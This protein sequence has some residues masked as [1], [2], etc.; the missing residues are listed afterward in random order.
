MEFAGR[1]AHSNTCSLGKCWKLKTGE[2]TDTMIRKMKNSVDPYARSYQETD[3]GETPNE[4][5]M[6]RVYQ[7]AQNKIKAQN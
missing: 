5:K 7:E 3:W 6:R 2:Q 4:L 1:P